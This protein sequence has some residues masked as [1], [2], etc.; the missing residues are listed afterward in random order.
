MMHTDTNIVSS[1]QDSL[2]YCICIFRLV[3]QDFGI[4]V[5]IATHFS[6]CCL[7]LKGLWRHAGGK[8]RVL[9]GVGSVNLP[10]D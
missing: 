2:V 6:L 3:I 1:V 8:N 4:E 7:L 10:V 9:L 5:G